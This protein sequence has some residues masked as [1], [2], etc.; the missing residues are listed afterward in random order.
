MESVKV[1]GT[2]EFSTSKGQ[3]L[4]VLK[5]ASVESS[6]RL[7]KRRCFIEL[8]NPVTSF[9]GLFHHSRRVANLEM[10]IHP[11][12]ELFPARTRFFP[13]PP[14]VPEKHTHV[15][16]FQHYEPVALGF[17][18][19]TNEIAI[20]RDRSIEVRNLQQDTTQLRCIR[21]GCSETERR[22]VDGLR[23]KLR[24]VAM[25]LQKPIEARY[26]GQT[27]FASISVFSLRS[28]TMLSIPTH[29]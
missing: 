17:E 16:R 19:K 10:R 24:Q 14:A 25:T 2:A 26:R 8:D 20:E 28:V 18:A 15:A 4:V 7:R 13:V 27:M 23:R 29:W 12:P 3:T 22:D 5:A 21:A 9:A 1:T 6:D 11:K